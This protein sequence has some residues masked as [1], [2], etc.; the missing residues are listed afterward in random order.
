MR[1]L[2]STTLKLEEFNESEIP[3]YAILS[4]AW[5]KDEVLFKYIEGETAKKRAAFSKVRRCCERA[6]ADGFEC[7]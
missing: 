6:V 3:L 2:K 7:V 4:H 5:G 1:L